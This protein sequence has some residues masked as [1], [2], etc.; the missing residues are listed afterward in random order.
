MKTQI[1]FDFLRGILVACIARDAANFAMYALPIQ[2]PWSLIPPMTQALIVLA[3]AVYAAVLLAFLLR[4]IEAIKIVSGVLFTMAVIWV[5]YVLW[6]LFAGAPKQPSIS[7]VG[8]LSLF[9]G[10][11]LTAAISFFCVRKRNSSQVAL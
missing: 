2:F 3:I 6:A 10:P 5:C 9:S 7:F 1:T 11:P 8:V 4:P